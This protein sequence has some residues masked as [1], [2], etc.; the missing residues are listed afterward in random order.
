MPRPR[1][2]CSTLLATLVV[3]QLLFAAHGSLMA[4]D[5]GSEYLK[6]CL[7]KPGRTPISIVVNEMSRRKSPALVG[8]VE[9]GRVL[10]EEAY[11]LNIRYP[12]SIFSQLR[13]L[14]GRSAN[15]AE[16]KRVLED[17]LL[18]YIVNDHPARGTAALPYN[19]TTTYLI[20][21][22]VVGIEQAA[23]ADHV[24][25]KQPN[26]SSYGGWDLVKTYPVNTQYQDS[27]EPE[28]CM[29]LE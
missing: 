2:V 14:L 9:E 24:N 26:S 25:S 16:V 19:D 13:N 18:P 15:D 11:S 8:L 21:E 20:E 10:G 22:L 7:V 3:C 27:T 12:N 17:N 5:L 6:V 28:R 1:A 4:V 23:E 29:R